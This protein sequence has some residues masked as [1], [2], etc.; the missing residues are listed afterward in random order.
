MI[1][2]YYKFEIDR[3]LNASINILN[4]SLRLSKQ[5]RME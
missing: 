1:Y 4:E 3:D 5:T 2:L